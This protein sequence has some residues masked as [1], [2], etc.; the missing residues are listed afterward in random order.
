MTL[1]INFSVS[2]PSSVLVILHDH[3][4]VYSDAHTHNAVVIAV[5]KQH[6]AVVARGAVQVQNQRIHTVLLSAYVGNVI[7][8]HL[9]LCGWIHPL[10]LFSC[11]NKNNY[12]IRM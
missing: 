11:G 6:G 1:N 3:R 7:S 12:C 8:D 10:C 5:P 4:N 9:F 2:I